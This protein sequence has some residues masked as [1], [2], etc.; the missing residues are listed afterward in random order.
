ITYK[1]IIISDEK[2][3]PSPKLPTFSGFLILSQNQSSSISLSNRDIK[4]KVSYIVILAPKDIG[5]LKIEPS[6][7]RVR[8]KVYYT[9]GFEIEV[10]D[11]GLNNLSPKK[12]K[13][14]PI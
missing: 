10:K 1:L 5:K 3:I 9:D 14:L 4:T 6:S 12:T 8:G 2:V 11:T 7:I 13:F